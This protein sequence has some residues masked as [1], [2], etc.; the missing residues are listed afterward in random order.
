MDL[1]RKIAGLS[2]I[3]YLI[4]MLTFLA[5]IIYNQY[6]P[7]QRLILGIGAGAVLYV[8]TIL[9]MILILAREE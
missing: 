3:G 7:D 5:L 4:G 1:E 2:V 6:F 9:Q 8:S